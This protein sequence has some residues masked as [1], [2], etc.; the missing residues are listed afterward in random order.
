MSQLDSRPV[1]APTD[2][3]P[4]YVR[5][6]DAPNQ[7]DN[8]IAGLGDIVADRGWTASVVHVDCIIGTA[9]GRSQVEKR[10]AEQ[11]CDAEH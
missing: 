2:E 6:A 1:I 5:A 4:I 10:D 7:V 9:K 11:V 8:R 3:S